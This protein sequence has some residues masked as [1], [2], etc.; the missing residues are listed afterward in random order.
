MFSKKKTKKLNTPGQA[1]STYLNRDTIIAAII[2]AFPTLIAL[3]LNYSLVDKIRTDIAEQTLELEKIKINM[4]STAQQLESRKIQIEDK[5]SQTEQLSLMQNFIKLSNE[6]RPNLD[7]SCE[8]PANFSKTVRITCKCVN[9][10]IHAVK[11]IPETIAIL[12]NNDQTEIKNTIERIANAKANYINSGGKGA[13]TYDII[14]T[15]YGVTIKKPVFKIT[16]LAVTNDIAIN[17]GKRTLRGVINDKEM[18]KLSEMHYNY[19]LWL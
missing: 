1:A 10:G 18:K 12:D 4:A 2:I 7:I 15:D 13:D 19:Y 17:I 11:I 3:I 9:N 5:R 16:F 6:L 14:L 8:G